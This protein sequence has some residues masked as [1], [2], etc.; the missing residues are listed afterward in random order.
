MLF[1]PI[2][3]LGVEEWISHAAPT[4]LRDVIGHLHYKHFDPTGLKTYP[5]Q[6][7]QGRTANELSERRLSNP[8]GMYRNQANGA[9]FDTPS[10]TQPTHL[11]AP[12]YQGGRGDFPF[13]CFLFYLSMP[14]FRVAMKLPAFRV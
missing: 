4:E 14:I 5:Y 12:D 8:E 2:G 10:A 3:V 13:S 6:G 1:S 11:S 9:G 7:V